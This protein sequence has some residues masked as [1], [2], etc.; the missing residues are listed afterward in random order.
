[1]SVFTFYTYFQTLNLQNNKLKVLPGSLGSLKNLRSLNLS[2]N[3][4]KV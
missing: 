2:G 1:M 4:L 3:C